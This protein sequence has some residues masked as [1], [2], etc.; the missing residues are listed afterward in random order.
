MVEHFGRP[1]FVVPDGEEAACAEEAGGV[2]VGVEVGDVGD[3]AAE[4]F[5]PECEG[6]FPQEKFA[7]AG[8]EGGVED[9]AV[10]SVG[11]V[12]GDLDVRPPIPVGPAVV[13]EGELRGPAVVGLPRVVAALVDE[14]GAAII[15]HDE[16][17]VALQAFERGGEFAD[18]DAAHPVGGDFDFRARLP[19]AVAN[20]LGPDWRIGLHFSLERTESLHEASAI[21]AV[22]AEAEDIEG[23]ARCG[24][25]AD[26]KRNRLARADA[27]AGA[28]AFDPRATVFCF[29]VNARVREH[30]VARAGPGVFVADEAR[31]S[32]GE[33][34]RLPGECGGSGGDE[35][36]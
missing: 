13:V 18:I 32:L 31:L 15:A 12:V 29:R 3:V 4:G 6:E 7:G 34:R 22:V 28:V 21:A 33:K 9:L 1:V 5:E 11:A 16:D 30:P 35:V 8:G 24:I 36:F 26:V 14:V 19:R 25:G 17:D 20:T 27:G 10:F 23:E 2:A